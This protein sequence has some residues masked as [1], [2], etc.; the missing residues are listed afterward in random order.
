MHKKVVDEELENEDEGENV[1]HWTR[2]P[3]DWSQTRFKGVQDT[4]YRNNITTG[5]RVYNPETDSER[6]ARHER[7]IRQLRNNFSELQD[8]VN[9]VSNGANTCVG[10][11]KDRL[12][13]LEVLIE[14]RVM[15]LVNHYEAKRRLE[16]ENTDPPDSDQGPAPTFPTSWTTRFSPEEIGVTFGNAPPNVVYLSRGPAPVIGAD[17]RGK[18]KFEPQVVEDPTKRFVDEITTMMLVRTMFMTD[19]ESPEKEYN[20]VIAAYKCPDGEILLLDAKKVK[21]IPSAMTVVAETTGMGKEKEKE[22][23]K[24]VSDNDH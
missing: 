13:C 7:E 20:H 4:F 23:E 5:M 16:N 9:V 11:L 1:I 12:D 18:F 22:K 2:R 6:I 15:G 8:L 3:P 24:I 17:G 21:A 14:S 19:P 10:E